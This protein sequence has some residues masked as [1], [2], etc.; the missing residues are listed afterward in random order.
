MNNKIQRCISISVIFLLNCIIF[1]AI[2]GKNAGLPQVNH[3]LNKKNNGNAAR[4]KKQKN[5][6]N[7][8]NAQNK[9]PLE[10]A[11]DLAHLFA[12]NVKTEL[13]DRQ[14]K[15][16]FD[17]VGP[18]DGILSNAAK[19]VFT[20]LTDGVYL[21]EFYVGGKLVRGMQ[22]VGNESGIITFRLFR[23]GTA[24]PRT[25]YNSAT[26]T[27]QQELGKIGV[28]SGFALVSLNSGDKICLVNTSDLPV[29][30]SNTGGPLNAAMKIIQIT[31][32]TINGPV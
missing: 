9:T 22:N 10:G 7:R 1:M 15:V 14:G 30:L 5:K 12:T 20:V 28:V 16:D 18:I 21:I 19:T 4:L 8:R 2:E 3:V 31:G 29:L 26:Q 6:K 25:E 17:H 23:N 13:V 11:I 24:I 27:G 32:L